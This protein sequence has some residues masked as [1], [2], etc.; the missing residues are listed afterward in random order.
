MFSKVQPVLTFDFRKKNPRSTVDMKLTLRHIHVW[1][2]INLYVKADSAYQKLA[3]YYV[4]EAVFN[5]SNWRVINPFDFSVT[6]QAGNTLTRLFTELNY[7]LTY[8]KANKGLFIRLFAGVIAWDGRPARD[9]PPPDPGF[10]LSFSTGSGHYQKDFLF[11]EFF[12]ARNEITGFWSQQVVKKD[13]GFRTFKSSVQ[14]ETWI[15][16]LNLNS[17]IPGKVPIRPYV[18]LAIFGQEQSKFNLAFEAGLAIVVWQDILEINFP[19][20][21]LSKGSVDGFRKWYIGQNTQINSAETL[22]QNTKYWNL[23]TF[24]FNLKKL[25]PFELVKT[26][27][28]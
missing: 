4:N 15:V 2:D 5:Y 23:I 22:F 18:S 1:Q 12:F 9:Q 26:L 19:F 10:N 20:A 16:S 27:R 24:T 13:G 17:T 8:N 11:D 25:N 28:L 6:L 21:M 7:K 14:A 3:R